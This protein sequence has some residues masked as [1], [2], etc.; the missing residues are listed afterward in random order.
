MAKHILYI[1]DNPNDQRLVKKVLATQGY[2][3]TIAGD[4]QEG[5]DKAQT[6][7]PDLIL[8][9][10]QMP[11]LDGL[12]TVRRLRK[13]EGCDQVPVVALTAYAEKYKRELYLEAGFTDY[14]QK[15]A[16][17]RPLVE[18]VKRFLD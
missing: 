8:M 9:D 15:Q 4:G 1:E 14:Q 13:L 6:V 17:I 5:L 2:E 3:L 11:G 18:L 10:V 7:N 12:E 16:G